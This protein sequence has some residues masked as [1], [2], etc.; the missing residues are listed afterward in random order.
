MK[1]NKKG[2]SLVILIIMIIVMIILASVV[3]YISADM[4]NDSKK[5]AFVSDL[6]LIED[7]VDE[8]Y[9]NNETLPVIEEVS[10]SKSGFTALITEGIDELTNEISSNNDD[11]ATFYEVDLDKIDVQSTSRGLKLDG[12]NTDV[13]FVSS[14]TFNVYY[15]K[16][17]NIAGNYYFS[18]TESLT[19][20]VNVNDSQTDE[21]AS[22]ITITN[23]TKGIKLVKNTTEY[24]NDLKVTVTTTLKTGETM[25]YKIANQ[26]ISVE[27]NIINISNILL[28]NNTIKSSFY[29]SDSN[30]IL[31]AQKISSGNIIAE[32][33]VSLA[34]LDLLSGTVVPSSNI[35]YSNNGNFILANISGYV[36]LGGSGVKEARVVYTVR[37]NADNSTS[38]YY[39]DLPNNITK[40]YVKNSGKS[41]GPNILRLPTDVKGYAL[42]FID[43]AGNI[44]DVA[45]YTVEY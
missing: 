10:Y 23:V 6:T 25:L 37:K 8:Y 29:E 5:A 28:N 45:N 42:V 44:S 16:G 12:D 7:L 31:I 19:G 24:T 38:P 26:E 21:D 3:I 11:E 27:E 4:V 9:L 39:N 20:K 1:R 22:N 2:I 32:S 13:Y 17:E 14:K 35:T 36:D 33:K 15:L 43:N 34:N 40:E 18:L 30:K 41:F